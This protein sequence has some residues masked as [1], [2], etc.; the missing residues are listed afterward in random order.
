MVKLKK[1]MEMGYL[2]SIKDDIA[3]IVDEIV[4]L[5]DGKL[6][7]EEYILLP[8]YGHIILRFDLNDDDIKIEDIDY[9]EDLMYE[10]SHGKFL[11]S[12]MGNVYKKVGLDLDDIP[13]LL[14]KCQDKYHDISLEKGPYHNKLQKIGKM[15]LK[16]CKI[17]EN[18]PIW[19]IQ[20]DDDEIAILL[21]S[22]NKGALKK[23]D[24]I[25]LI[26]VDKNECE[27]L[28]KALFKARHDRISL[29]RSL[30]EAR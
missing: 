3:K 29:V 15:L 17:D 12:F 22:T 5:S 25:V 20:I 7:Y 4:S 13:D 16:R 1:V 28:M 27:G 18:L 11:F 30:L 24:N 6:H 10:N 19:E 8:Y 21:L 26:E 23:V 2:D 9:Y 14:L